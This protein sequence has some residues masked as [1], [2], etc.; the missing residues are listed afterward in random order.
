MVGVSPDRVMLIKADMAGGRS[1]G[2]GT[3]V[4][5]SV[6]LTAAHV[7]FDDHGRPANRVEVGGINAAPVAAQVI[8]PPSYTMAE[9]SGQLDVA[10][11][12]IT[13][14][15]WVAPRLAAVRWGRLTG[16]R[17]GVKCEAT[18]F[19]RA[20]VG[21]GGIRD[22]DQVSAQINPGSRR[23]A[24]RYDLTVTSAVPTPLRDKPSPWGG[25]SG[26]GVFANG[27]LVAVVIVDERGGYS[28]DRLSAVPVYRLAS[29]AGFTDLVSAAGG[30]LSGPAQLESVEL[31][32]ILTPLHLRALRRGND[33]SRS[34]AMLLRPEMGVVPFHG[35]AELTAA[36]IN[37]CLD[38][39][40]EVGVRML[41]GPGGQGK[42]RM[43]HHLAEHLLWLPPSTEDSPRW[44]CGFLDADVDERDLVVLADTDAPLLI[45]V[46]YAETRSQQLR[47]LLPLLWAADTTDPVRVLLLARAAGEWWDGLAR[48]LDG[49]P[50]EVTPLGALDPVQD[51][52]AQFAA[53]VAAFD[54]RLEDTA[55]AEATSP[56]RSVRPPADISHDRYGTPLTLQL[57]ALTAVLEARHSLAGAAAGGGHAEDTLLRHEERYWIDTAHSAGLDLS[58]TTLRPLVA[59][60]TLCGAGSFADASALA[61]AVPRT[62]DLSQDQLYRLDHWLRSL[63]P[64]ESGQRWGSLQPDRLGE[65]LIATTLPEIPGLLGALLAPTDAGSSAGESVPAP[66]AASAAWKAIEWL[67]NRP[68][69]PSR[70]TTSAA[71]HHRALTILA[72]ALGNPALTEPAAVALF[73]QV[74][75][76][77][78]GD[79]VRLGPVTLQVI[80]ETAY[81]VPM[82]AALRASAE[83][84]D[85]VVLAQLLGALPRSSL[86]LADLAAEWTRRRVAY[87]RARVGGTTVAKVPWWRV[88]LRPARSDK[89]ASSLLDLSRW[90]ADL[91]RHEEALAACVEATDIY[92]ELVR[93]R[94][95]YTAVLAVS[96]QDMSVRVAALGNQEHALGYIQAAVARLRASQNKRYGG[97]RPWWAALLGIGPI[98]GGGAP[99]ADA[100]LPALASALVTQSA[101]LAR[102]GRREEALAASTEAV[103]TYRWLAWWFSTARPG[104]FTA[105]LA[106]ALNR[107]SGALAELGRGEEALAAITEAVAT[108]RW[109]VAARPDEFTA[110][111]AMVLNNQTVRLVEMGR[112]EEA[113]AASTEAVATYQWLAWRF[114]AARPDAFRA[115]L[116]TAQSNQSYAATH[117]GR[118]RQ[119]ERA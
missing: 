50:G 58:A 15:S 86:S 45:V 89:L 49:V 101:R 18:G 53:A 87:L 63:Y 95:S 57:A 52:G 118:R 106:T 33:P 78:S 83:T 48:D 115:S 100:F 104:A 76:S 3:L 10:L 39:E 102:L 1:V 109:L 36:L 13:D 119:E 16:R 56:A 38:T 62:S 99:P 116:A 51:R 97:F 71:R 27:V 32:G 77:L 82:L 46:D 69:A 84:A 75:D 20:L 66:A 43:A 112:W 80:T 31:Q 73:T 24:G 55:R 29:D 81:P 111:L 72:R 40:I 64:P 44:V 117:L 114:S 2:S 25:L 47:R 28:G 113:L 4:G 37:W 105:S 61:S 88:E 94:S 79:L 96:L 93:L 85:Q 5:P 70:P 92:W 91:G 34:P 65:Y 8:W 30:G 60:A 26:A 67:R 17:P 74:R 110:D 90:L 98:F 103:A 54:R 107:H 12:Q 21:P 7:V 41:T 22:T 9:N 35:R 42:T 14:P 6:V 19:P 59:A 23:V 68:S 11:V 108:Y